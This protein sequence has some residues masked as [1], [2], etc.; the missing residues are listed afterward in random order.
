M[1]ILPKASKPAEKAEPEHRI[2]EQ[3]EQNNTLTKIQTICARVLSEKTL[4]PEQNFFDSGLSSLQLAQIHE[5]IDEEFPDK[6][7]ITDIFD[8]PTMIEVAN[9]ID[10]VK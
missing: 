5:Q 9:F 4:D 3:A 6:L 7:D 1:S 2:N 10:N 8:H